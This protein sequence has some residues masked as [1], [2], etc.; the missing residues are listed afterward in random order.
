MPFP[1]RSFDCVVSIGCFHH[2]GNVWRCLSETA[3]VLKP[4]GTAIIM[5]YK[6]SLRQWLR[7]PG[8]TFREMLSGRCRKTT[9]RRGR[10]GADDA[11]IATGKPCPVTTFVSIG[12]L[13]SLLRLWFTSAL[14]NGIDDLMVKGKVWIMRGRSRLPRT[15]F[16]AG[17]LFASDQTSSV[18][19]Q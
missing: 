10:R 4:G 12:E 3:R 5:L 11:S 9:R 1:D 16:G 8:K 19:V 6:F 14:M 13:R 7:R 17:H 18:R 15:Y 2:T